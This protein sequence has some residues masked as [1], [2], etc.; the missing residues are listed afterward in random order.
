VSVEKGLGL[1]SEEPRSF[2]FL[3]PLFT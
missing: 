2:H 3:L 1:L